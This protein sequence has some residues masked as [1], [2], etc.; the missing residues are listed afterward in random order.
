[1]DTDEEMSREAHESQ[2]DAAAPCCHK[3][4]QSENQVAMVWCADPTG[5][6]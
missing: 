1:M 2:R 5:E 3:C 6:A 4:H